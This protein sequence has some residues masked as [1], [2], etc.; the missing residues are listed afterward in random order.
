MSRPL[1]GAQSYGANVFQKCPQWPG[2]DLVNEND[3]TVEQPVV[4][5]VSEC[6]ADS[7]T[8]AAAHRMSVFALTRQLAGLQRQDRSQTFRVA[9]QIEQVQVAEETKVVRHLA[10]VLCQ[11]G[12]RAPRNV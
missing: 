10:I 2:D 8:S 6:R 9:Q 1:A 12:V 3:Q 4:L 11:K 7:V 5:R